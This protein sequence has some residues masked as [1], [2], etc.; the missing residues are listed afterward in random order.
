VGAEL[1]GTTR[2]A[3]GIA[4]IAGLGLLAAVAMFF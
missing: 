4:E 3:K 1:T 2:F